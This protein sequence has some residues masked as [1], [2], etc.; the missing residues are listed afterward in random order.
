MTHPMQHQDLARTVLGVLTLGLLLVTT[1]WILS[2]F[3]LA[4]IW[5]TMIAV[6]T[7]PLLLG[8]Q[9][10]LRNSRTLAVL[11]MT[12]GMLL[13]LILPVVMGVATILQNISKVKEWITLLETSGLPALPAWLGNLPLVGQPIAAKWAEAAAAGPE[14]VSAQLALYTQKALAW[15]A[16]NAGNMGMVVVQLLLT[17]ILT[18][19]LYAQ[20]ETAAKGVRKFF[21]RL[22]GPRGEEMVILAGKAIRAVAMGIVVTAL[23]QSAL[24]GIG[25][26]VAGIPGAGLLT[27]V[28]FILAIAQIGVVPVMLVAVGWLFYKKITAWA[29][30][31]LV[32]SAVVGRLDNIIRPILSKRGA[33][34]PLLL[35][36]GGVLGGLVAFGVIGLFVGPV[37]LAVSYTLVKAWVND[38]GAVDTDVPDES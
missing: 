28:M 38:P 13:V 23:I 30:A 7:W 10:R 29:I 18:A 9:Q 36:L 12:V 32:W 11:V 8:A 25:L 21:R 33:D 24:G 6:A 3:L 37:V 26:W 5:A 4:L 31:L 1:A 17:L 20:G 14:G 19:V 35:I 15:I 2:P 34:L 22:A 16:G 27:A